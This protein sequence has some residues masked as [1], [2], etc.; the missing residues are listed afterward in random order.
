M[1]R[2]T[3]RVVDLFMDIFTDEDFNDRVEDMNTHYNEDLDL[4]KP[5]LV[6][7]DDPPTVVTP[8][9]FPAIHVWGTGMNNGVEQ[10]L[11][12]FGANHTIRIAVAVQGQERIQRQLYRY[13]DLI[14]QVIDEV[15]KGSDETFALG[16]DIDVEYGEPPYEATGAS[17]VQAIVTVQMEHAEALLLEVAP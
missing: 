16:G 10:P 7:L 1:A 2:L 6:V 3:E 12:Q 17:V 8:R 11:S 4:L 14:L 15:T 5:I 9:N 13:T